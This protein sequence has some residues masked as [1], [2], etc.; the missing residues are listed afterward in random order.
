LA[1]QE[2]ED[3]LLRLNKKQTDQTVELE[4][5]LAQWEMKMNSR[6]L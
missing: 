4:F 6:V 5:Q 3:F 1:S 2:K